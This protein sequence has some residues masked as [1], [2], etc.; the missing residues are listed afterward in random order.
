MA[1]DLG[2][3][4]FGLIADTA[5]LN[6]AISV[7]DRFSEK[8]NRAAKSTTDAAQA[9]AAALARQER[10][11][12]AV[13]TKAHEQ[14]EA[15]QRMGGNGRKIYN[16]LG[17]AVEEYTAAMTKGQLSSIQFG[18]AQA[19]ASAQLGE[20][21][22]KIKEQTQAMKEQ[23][24]VQN[25]LARANQ[26]AQNL[27]F[28]ANRID[29][30]ANISSDINKAY[31]DLQAKLSGAR[32]STNALGQAQRD[33]A[34]DIGVADR[35]LKQYAADLKEV[36]SQQKLL[37][38]AQRR[39][40]MAMRD[41]AAAQ[42]D[43]KLVQAV[44]ASLGNYTQAVRGGSN[45]AAQSA[46][47]KQLAADLAKLDQNVGA[48]EQKMAAW[49][50][51][52]RNMERAT[53]LVTGP[54]SSVGARIGIIGAL[55]EST[56]AT[57]AIWI[58]SF[59]AVAATLGFLGVKAVEATNRFEQINSQMTAAAGI[60]ALAGEQYEFV[61]KTAD[62]L[63]KNVADLAPEYAKFATAARLS[64]LSV[65]EQQKIYEN[66][67]QASAG[68]RLSTEKT[69]L[70]FKALT[71]M[72][73]KGTVQAEE[74]KQQLGDSL[75][76]A[77]NLMAA[78]AN[79]STSEFAKMSEQGQ[80]M[81][82]DV[83]LPFSEKAAQTFGGA[84][85]QGAHTLS[86]ELDRL[87]GRFFEFSRKLDQM[88][89][90][91][92]TVKGVLV[93]TS[94]ALQF[95]TNNMEKLGAV[96]GALIGGTLG[97]MAIR[98]LPLLVTGATAA[99]SA[100]MGLTAASAALTFSNPITGIIALTVGLA[101]AAL[102][103]K[104]MGDAA[105]KAVAP[106]DTLMAQV[107]QYITA[108][109]DFGVQQRRTTDDLIKK[110]EQYGNA[111]RYRL[112]EVLDT[113]AFLEKAT[114]NVPLWRQGENYNKQ[115]DNLKALKAEAENLRKSLDDAG[116]ALGRL[117]EMSS[118][119][120]N[121]DKI[122]D[123]KMTQALEGLKDQIAKYSALKS[124]LDNLKGKGAEGGLA[125]MVK[126]RAMGDAEA[127]LNQLGDRPK[128]ELTWALQAAGMKGSSTVELL[129]DLIAKTRILGEEYTNAEQRARRLPEVIREADEKQR[130]MNEAIKEAGT[131]SN[132]AK[133]YLEVSKQTES[134]ARPLIKEIGLLGMST[135]EVKDRTDA[136]RR[137]LL[138][139]KAIEL[140]EKGKKAF[141]DVNE[142]IGNA[143]GSPFASQSAKID[144]WVREQVQL[145]DA[146]MNFKGTSENFW[147]GDA[148]KKAAIEAGELEKHISAIKIT[149]AAQ[150][151]ADKWQDEAHSLAQVGLQADFANLKVGTYEAMLRDSAQNKAYIEKLSESYNAWKN[152]L[153]VT[154]T[155]AERNTIEEKLLS[156]RIKMTELSAKT[157]QFSNLMANKVG[158]AFYNSLDSILTRTATWG[159]AI[160]N[161]FKNIGLEIARI[162]TKSIAED[163][164]ASLKKFFKSMNLDGALG[165]K[166]GGG[167]ILGLLA[168]PFGQ[169]GNAMAG[170]DTSALASA[171]AQAELW[172]ANGMAGLAEGGRAGSVQW[173]GEKGPEIW[174]PDSSGVVVPN[175]ALGGSEMNF[176]QS[177]TFNFAGEVR[178][179][180][181]ISAVQMGRSLAMKDFL[182]DIKRGGALSRAIG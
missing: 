65:E 169:W 158:D 70:V 114:N 8:V 165:G 160:T 74:V 37:D 63:G 164:A 133:M 143:Q 44:Q 151:F 78:A 171:T 124:S 168:T 24:A 76:G 123:P 152:I 64:G 13:I 120:N 45:T 54:L 177:M 146:M 15:I 116:N 57:T 137:S 172:S 60:S 141:A 42:S 154:T 89:G 161:L 20:V 93:A 52:M 49:I 175:K 113:M 178:R 138:E 174:V 87:L 66:T 135:K 117:G 119:Q 59:A 71:D 41:A 102:G 35:A 18:R 91:S 56:N 108:F 96:A 30:P 182:N 33:F 131:N 136:Y 98:M 150:S 75:P 38:A 22:N 162:F 107:N 155:F 134:F 31:A 125:A 79:K 3:I 140:G 86:A 85:T 27:T 99:S 157:E 17:K 58:G 153:A 36:E 1:L 105:A 100:I 106:Q 180:D 159:E 83:L 40:R 14:E 112:K 47:A 126:Q 142:R 148:L 132:L 176:A 167:G 82:R 5:P 127:Q 121:N 147:K 97:M 29:A 90:L 101:G 11:I 12:A 50:Q 163:A 173:V 179:G 144:E 46:A 130:M 94:N 16:E 156:I 81:S 139:L 77:F 88:I 34:A 72:L 62:K 110:V 23:E 9:Q 149:M 122:V 19:A 68:L 28:R 170:V 43:P 6:R 61:F 69:A 7:L 92:D 10:A 111:A 80:I 145:A 48:S 67:M 51:T 39:V 128:S 21:G 181:L 104:I 2:N 118:M 32:V 103:Y 95:M 84:A 73:S 115:V 55:M 26:R 53:I 129:A 166:G 109:D 25:A 4:S